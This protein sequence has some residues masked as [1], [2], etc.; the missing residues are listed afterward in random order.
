[1]IP[2]IGEAFAIFAAF[3]YAFESVAATRNAQENGGRGNAVLLSIVL[4]AGFLG[5]LWLI[6]GPP[7]PVP[8]AGADLWIGIAWFALAGVLATVLG[9]VLFFR[10]IDLAGAI[11]TGILRRLMPV[12]ATVLA[13]LVLDEAITPAIGLAFL[14][15]FSDVALVILA[16][17]RRL[18]AGFANSRT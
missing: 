6:L 3:C 10:S 8:V 15:V 1:M 9:R 2:L 12:F 16:A 5:G 4:T 13:I 18:V 17:P 7:V 11:E 14:L